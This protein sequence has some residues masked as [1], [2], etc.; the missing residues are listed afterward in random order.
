MQLF[1]TAEGKA[2]FPGDPEW[3][4]LLPDGLPYFQEDELLTHF[5]VRP[6]FSQHSAAFDAKF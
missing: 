5:E 3:A 1:G 2:L 6:F 4:A